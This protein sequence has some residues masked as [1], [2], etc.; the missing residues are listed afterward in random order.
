MGEIWTFL[1]TP[2]TFQL[3]LL[4]FNPYRGSN[5][6]PQVVFPIN[7]IFYETISG[8][9]KSHLGMGAIALSMM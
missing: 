3:L 1:L 7:S 8:Y 2:P 6:Y 5:L 4:T 9:H